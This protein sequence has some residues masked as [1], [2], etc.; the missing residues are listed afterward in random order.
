MFTKLR[1]KWGWAKGAELQSRL[2]EAQSRAAPPSVMIG[3]R[4]R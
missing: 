2:H 1:E 4:R 3:S